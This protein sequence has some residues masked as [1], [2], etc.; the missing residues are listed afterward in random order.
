MAEDLFAS[1]TLDDLGLNWR[2]HLEGRWIRFQHGAREHQYGL[3]GLFCLALW[4]RHV[5][6]GWRDS[7]AV[8][9]SRK[10]A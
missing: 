3:W 9:P 10:S 1:G 8:Q 7:V 2:P 5:L 4:Q 6:V